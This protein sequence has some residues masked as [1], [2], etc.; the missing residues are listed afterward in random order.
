M[1][2]IIVVIVIG[3]L[4]LYVHHKSKPGVNNDALPSSSQTKS[5]QST[6]SKTETTTKYLV[7][8]EWGVELPLS[9]AVSDAYYTVQGSSTGTDGLPD[10][11]WIGLAS[12][13]ASGC[14][15]ATTDPSSSATPLGSVIR[16]LPTDT[17]PVTGELYAHQDPNG[18][19]INGF[20]YA[21]LPWK[22]ATCAPANALQTDDKAFAMAIKEMVPP[23][24]MDITQWSV[25]LTLSSTTASLY[26]YIKAGQ[27]NV[28]YLSLGSV[29]DVASNCSADQTSLGAIVRLTP[30]EQKIAPDATY[31]IPGTVHIANYW[32]GYERSPAACT[33]GTDAMNAAVSNA[34]PNFNASTLSNTFNTITA[35]PTSN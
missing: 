35:D 21:F 14:D 19:T 33:D 7:I 12:L 2:I 5:Q 11:A 9:S 22:N 8:K 18:V 13:N 26:Y 34:A 29:A 24:Y 27:P 15:I 4:G 28:A 16:V 32:Y 6:P 17:D 20:Y 25:R 23:P 1:I 31:S 10:T 30:A 3:A